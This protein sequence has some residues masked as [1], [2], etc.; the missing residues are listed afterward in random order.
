MRIIYKVKDVLGMSRAMGGVAG[1]VGV[2]ARGQN[3]PTHQ[4]PGHGMSRSG[5]SDLHTVPPGQWPKEGPKPS[6]CAVLM[7]YISVAFTI[8]G[9]IM[10]I[11]AAMYMEEDDKPI[12]LGVGLCLA[13]GGI[14]LIAIV[15]VITRLEQEKIMNYL[16]MKVEELRYHENFRKMPNHQE[17]SYLVPSEESMA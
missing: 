15:N 3:D 11:R 16:D 6:K 7:Y 5:S 10:V 14:A 2:D 13:T 8:I 4:Q 12:A 17:A 1:G 9:I